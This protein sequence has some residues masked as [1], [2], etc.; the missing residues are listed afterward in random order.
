M[1]LMY[2][3]IFSSGILRFPTVRKFT[4]NNLASKHLILGDVSFQPTGTLCYLNLPTSKNDTFN[5]GVKIPI[6]NS[7]PLFPVNTLSKYIS[8][9]RARG[10]A[11]SSPLFLN[12]EVDASP[13]SRSTFILNLKEV[14]SRAGYEDQKFSGHSFRIGACTTGAAA[15]IEDHMLQVLGRW[16]SGCYMRY[17]RTQLQSISD[18]QAKMSH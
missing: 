14:L 10:A 18:A 1:D 9:R 16:K 4:G 15:G 17:I 2:T 6:F 7:S 5:E 11:P 8:A 3:C 12:S 13:L